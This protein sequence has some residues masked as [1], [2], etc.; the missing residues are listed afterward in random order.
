ME[1]RLGVELMAKRLFESGDRDA[2]HQHLEKILAGGKHPLAECREDPNEEKPY[3]V[4][5][6]AD[7]RPESP[8]A[9]SSPEL[10]STTIVLDDDA[11]DQLADAVAARLGRAG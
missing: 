1:R 7:P 8:P 6:G 10:A 9:S 5:D 3:Q 2:A 4:W 11:I